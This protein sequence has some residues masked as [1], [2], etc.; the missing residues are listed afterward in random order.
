MTSNHTHPAYEPA[1]NI[2]YPHTHNHK[3]YVKHW[4]MIYELSNYSCCVDCDADKSN[5]H[6]LSLTT[7]CDDLRNSVDEILQ[8]KGV[9]IWLACLI[10][11]IAE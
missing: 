4:M 5:K 3:E 1:S 7:D 9:K 8:H 10:E 11:K 6:F 2:D